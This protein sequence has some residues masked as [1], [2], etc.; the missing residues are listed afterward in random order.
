[1]N[2]QS[3]LRVCHILAYQTRLNKLK[4]KIQIPKIYPF[5][6]GQMILDEGAKITHR[7]KVIS[8]IVLGKVIVL[9]KK[10]AVGFLLCMLKI[11]N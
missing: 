7:K 11:L 10:K 3:I 4:D 5:I 9:I 6:Y 1:M 8:T 2:A